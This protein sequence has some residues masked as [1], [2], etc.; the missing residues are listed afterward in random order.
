MAPHKRAREHNG[1]AAVADE[2]VGT[3]LAGT[4]RDCAKMSNA[5]VHAGFV[6][7]ADSPH[8]YTLRVSARSLGAC[9]L[10]RIA[11]IGWNCTRICNKIIVNYSGE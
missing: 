7:A 6:K 5:A 9:V 2:A 4:A 1:V 11:R 8:F 3:L 10:V